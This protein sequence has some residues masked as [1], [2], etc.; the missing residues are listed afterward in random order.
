MQPFITL[1]VLIDQSML[2]ELWQISWISN[3][4]YTTL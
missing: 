2:L 3:H 1:Q 4:F